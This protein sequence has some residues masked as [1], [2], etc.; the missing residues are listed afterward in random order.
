[1]SFAENHDFKLLIGGSYVDGEE[2][3]N[4]VNPATGAVFAQAPCAS[5]QQ[6]IQAVS[7][8]N[9]AFPLWRALSHG[10]RQNALK[11]LADVINENIS[12]LATLLTWEQGKPLEQ[13]QQE[14][15][16]S[17]MF[18]E[19]FA[20]LPLPHEFIEGVE[21]N[22][23]EVAFEPL[24]VIGAIVPWNF[25]ILL[26]SFKL[27]PAL[28]SGNCVILKTA[29][30]TPLTTLRI[31]ELGSEIFPPGVLNVI[32]GGNEI[33]AEMT[34]SEDI[35][36]I[37]FTGSTTTGKKVM[38]AA[39]S[40]ITRLT[41][42]LGGNDPAVVLDDADIAITAEGIFRAAFMNAGQTCIAIKR[43]YVHE[44][45]FEPLFLALAKLIDTAVVGD[46]LESQTTIGPIQNK[47]QYEKIRQLMAESIG[48][49]ARIASAP[50]PSDE[51]YFIEPTI[52]ANIAPNCPLVIDEQFGP[53]L[54]VIPFTSE[55]EVIKTINN[56]KFG[57]AASIWST[58]VKHAQSLAKEIQ[59][60]TI[61]INQHL[62]L[63][64]LVHLGGAKQSGFGFEL[65]ADVLKSFMQEKSIMTNLI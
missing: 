2:K 61:W 57:L 38:A 55:N 15:A 31:A 5:K 26:S 22:H 43:V 8:A 36:K 9:T 52:V 1:M 35:H 32:T 27:G 7:S 50:I 63:S 60:G 58:N 49:E 29:P 20:S 39:A 53:I 34:H 48:P 4:V 33:G 42:E 59:A 23:V 41:L 64:P 17:A 18:L 16:L 54:P 40:N 56:S 28:V 25:P 37:A 12:E 44:T 51:G 30:T 3:I 24:G 47:A 21:N 11:S 46:G 62:N 6:L 10:D 14:I 19:Y 13:A 65:G 45:L